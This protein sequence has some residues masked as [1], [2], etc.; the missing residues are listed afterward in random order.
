M[1]DHKG[2]ILIVDDNKSILSTLDIL[3]SPE[4]QTVTALSNPNQIPSELSKQNY[5]VVILDMNFKAGVNTGNEGIYWLV[6]IK[7]S[8]PD[9]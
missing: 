2:N 3:L 4:F 8:D 5:N 1:A 6:R 9:I 7:E